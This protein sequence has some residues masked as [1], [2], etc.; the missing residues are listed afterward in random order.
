MARIKDILQ[1]MLGEDSIEYL[2]EHYPSMQL[3]A[4]LSEEELQA[5]PGVTKAKAKQLATA[6]RVGKAC[7]EPEPTETLCA[8]SPADVFN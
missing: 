5:V 4:N 3:F 6:I 2:A 8:R 7:L 1:G